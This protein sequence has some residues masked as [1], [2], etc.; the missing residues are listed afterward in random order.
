MHKYNEKD[1]LKTWNSCSHTKLLYRIS[2]QGVNKSPTAAIVMTHIQNINNKLINLYNFE[3]LVT[4]YSLHFSVSVHIEGWRDSPMRIGSLIQTFQIASVWIRHK[5]QLHWSSRAW[6]D[7][8]NNSFEWL[9]FHFLRSCHMSLTC[10]ECII[11]LFALLLC[12]DTAV[13][14]WS[15]GAY[16]LDLFLARSDAQ[17]DTDKRS[18]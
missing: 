4:I 15:R 18:I 2:K 3:K 8:K 6:M 1:A 7:L 9:M 17:Y 14:T 13:S 12:T 16:T 11:K 5:C 10:P